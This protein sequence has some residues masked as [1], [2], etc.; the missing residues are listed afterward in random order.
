MS[1]EYVDIKIEN[2]N[3]TIQHF[4]NIQ[5]ESTVVGAFLGS[6]GY[7]ALDKTA[8]NKMIE[9][10]EYLKSVRDRINKTIELQELSFEEQS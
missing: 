8:Y 6:D 3:K 2:I 5:F 7:N 9:D 4:R 10:I 1:A